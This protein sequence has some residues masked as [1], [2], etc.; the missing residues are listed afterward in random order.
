MRPPCL[1]VEFTDFMVAV[2][3]KKCNNHLMNAS[4]SPAAATQAQASAPAATI[5]P[6][7]PTAK[8][9]H[10]ALPKLE[11]APNSRVAVNFNPLGSGGT[12]IQGEFL[13]TTHYEFL[14]IRLPSTPGLRSKLLPHMRVDI[15]YVDGGARNQFAAEIIGFTQKP[16]FLLFTSYPDRMS[17]METR[18]H[19]RVACA[20]PVSFVSPYGEGVGIISDLSRGGCRVV[21]EMT[22]QSGL[23]KLKAG[24]RLVLQTVFTWDKPA[25]KGVGIVRNVEI[26]GARMTLGLAFGETMGE[27]VDALTRYLSLISVLN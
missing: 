9:H 21:L 11:L 13:G 26:S 23:R 15:S 18:N 14:I 3:C 10:D 27:F 22:G 19:N 5:P 6:S 17:V 2:K 8:R 12:P 24:D 25:V 4:T 7:T 20:L 16:A 1:F